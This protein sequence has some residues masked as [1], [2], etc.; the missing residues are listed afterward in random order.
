VDPLKDK[1]PMVIE[2]IDDDIAQILRA[3]TGAESLRIANDM[4]ESARQML[5]SFL[6]SENP[7]WDD[8]RVQLEVVRRLSHGAI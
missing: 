8:A 7:E 2:V 3:K 1:R 5:S 4:Y 6:R